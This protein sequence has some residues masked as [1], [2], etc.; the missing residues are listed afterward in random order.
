MV[1]R[2]GGEGQGAFGGQGRSVLRLEGY[3]E[4][5]CCYQKD[6]SHSSRLLLEGCNAI[7]RREPQVTAHLV[8]VIRRTLPAGFLVR[9]GAAVACVV[10]ALRSSALAQPPP[11]YYEAV[12]STSSAS[13]RATLHPVIDDHTRFPYTSSS[14]DTWDI[15]ELAHQDLGDTGRI[16]DVYKNASYAKVGGG[17][18]PYNRE[19][20][21]PNSYGFPVD[22]PTNYPYTDCHALFL[23]DSSYNSSR[24]NTLYRFCSDLCSERP[25]D[26]NNGQGGGAGVYPGN[27]NW[28][29]GSGSTGTWETWIGRRG[30]VARALMY[31]DVRYEGGVHGGTGAPEPDLILTDNASLIETSGGRMPPSRTWDSSPT[32]SSGTHRTRSAQSRSAATMSWRG[33]RATETRSWTTRSGFDA[34]TS[35][36]APRC[37]VTASSLGPP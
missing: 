14:T 18:G 30:D 25:T 10:F 32:W 9:M 16:L 13:L 29:I 5:D 33:F 36:T 31:L 34:F 37:S 28:R 4:Q 20:S 21:W 2:D 12:D 1:H 17:T 22:G 35:T 19:H 7:P 11:G 27:S 8:S 26:V 6:S 3:R 23:A 15:L 24:G